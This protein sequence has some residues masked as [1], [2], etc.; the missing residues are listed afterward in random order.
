MTDNQGL[1]PGTQS[2]PSKSDAAGPPVDFAFLAAQTFDDRDLQ[3]DVL[4]LFV[5]QAR[6]VVP[7]LPGLSAREQA[8]AAHLLKGSAR[9]IGAWAAASAADAYE[10]AV[11]NQRAE[12]YRDLRAAFDAANA[13]IVAVLEAAQGSGSR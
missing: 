6:R 11:E 1:T 12:R 13:A 10:A 5:A 2:D 7:S 9:G 8:D 4:R 3:H